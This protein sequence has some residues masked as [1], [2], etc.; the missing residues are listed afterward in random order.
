VYWSEEIANQYPKETLEESK[1]IITE[2]QNLE[3]LILRHNSYA[4]FDDKRFKVVVTQTPTFFLNCRDL[5]S[6]LKLLITQHEFIKFSSPETQQLLDSHAT[7]LQKLTQL[8]YQHSSHFNLKRIVITHYPPKTIATL[9][10][11][12][13]ETKLEVLFFEEIIIVIII[14]TDNTIL[15]CRGSLHFHNM[16]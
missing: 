7:V 16:M 14:R 12:M 2:I 11:F 5:V 15:V 10:E 13:K 3:A 8:L 4:L 1:C 6:S 9:S